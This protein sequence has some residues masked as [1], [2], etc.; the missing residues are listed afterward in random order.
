MLA[1]R[2]DQS[3]T[4]STRSRELR[5]SASVPRA[6][7]PCRTHP[8]SAEGD[9]LRVR[10]LLAQGADRVVSLVGPGGIGKSRLAIESGACHQDLFPDGAFFVLLEGVLEPGL[11]APTIAY[12]SASATT[13]RPRSRSASRA[14]WRQARADRARQLRADRGSPRRCSSACTRLAPRRL[15]S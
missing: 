11:P 9:L 13:A 8:P 1:E 5:H 15:S 12:F 2:F 14:C 4:Q 10:E 6:V 3:R 7:F